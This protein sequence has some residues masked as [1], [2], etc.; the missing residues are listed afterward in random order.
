MT[1]KPPQSLQLKPEEI[2]PLIKARTHLAKAEEEKQPHFKYLELWKG[3]EPLYREQQK[4]QQKLLANRAAGRSAGDLDLMAA[5]MTS[6]SRP[7]VEQ[8]LTDQNIPE[9]HAA[10]ARKNMRKL[11][12]DNELLTEAGMTFAAWEEARKELRFN[13]KAN[14]WKAA[15]A[16]TRLLFIVRGACD[17]KVRKTDNLVSDEATL[18]LA[19]DL[20]RFIMRHLVEQLGE[21]NETFLSVGQRQKVAQDLMQKGRKA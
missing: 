2:P 5:C 11:L 20:L 17:P 9:L 15:G 1:F 12:G 8:I 19:Y 18:K 7:R 3:F 16:V 10:L 6:L 21:T 14:Y 13:L 4:G